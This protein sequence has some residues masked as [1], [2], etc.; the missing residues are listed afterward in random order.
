MQFYKKDA[1]L[2]QRNR[3]AIYSLIQQILSIKVKTTFNGYPKTSW[4]FSVFSKEW[5]ENLPN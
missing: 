1:I 5:I 2:N 3:R 4:N